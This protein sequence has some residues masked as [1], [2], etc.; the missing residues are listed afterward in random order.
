VHFFSGVHSIIYKTTTGESPDATQMNR[1]VLK[2]VNEALISEEVVAINS[3]RL[4]NNEQ[5]DMLAT[6]YMERLQRLPYKNTKVKLMEQLLK[7]VIDSVKQ[8]NKVKAVSFTDRLNDIIDQYNDRSDDIVLADE[9]VTEVAKQLADLFEEIK[10]ESVLPDGIPN[11]EVKAFYDILKSVAE[12]YV[13]LDE[14]TEEQ[15]I[16]LAKDVKEVVDDKTQYIDWDKKADIK[17][18]L[19]VQIILTLAKHKYPPATRDDVFKAIFEQAENFKKNRV[20]NDEDKPE[21]P[22]V[23]LY[24]RREV[25]LGEA[26]EGE[27]PYSKGSV[28]K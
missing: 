20:G 7:R 22:V 4:D 24:P 13:F 12:R 9:I 10:K 6:Q 3:M 27:V 1:H 14:Y 11:I 25:K 5:I 15:Y 16:A 19:K 2:L 23:H 26:A 8:V 18:Q 28:K 17:A 21:I